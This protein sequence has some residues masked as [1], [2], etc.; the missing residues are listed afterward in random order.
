MINPQ[1]I[2]IA[3]FLSMAGG[4]LYAIGMPSLFVDAG[5]L[6][7]FYAVIADN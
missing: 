4:L 6:M 7:M 3:G 1:I 2:L 5:V